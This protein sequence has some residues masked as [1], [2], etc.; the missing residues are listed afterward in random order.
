[1]ASDKAKSKKNPFVNYVQASYEELRKV[2]WPTRNQ[3]VRLTFLVLG[4]CL[5]VALVLGILDNVFGLGYRALVD[6]GPDRT[7]PVDLS[8]E[9]SGGEILDGGAMTITDSDGEEIT[10]DL[11]GEE[12]VSE[13][14]DTDAVEAT[15]TDEAAA[16]TEESVADTTEEVPTE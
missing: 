5:V 3:A 10:L 7:L 15:A 6:L 4:V 2:S 13:T 11:G 1:M 16:P 14:T 8:T 9:E 12:T